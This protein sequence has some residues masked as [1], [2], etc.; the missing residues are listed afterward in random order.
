MSCIILE[1][2]L[3]S[4]H[5]CTNVH[6]LL[7]YISSLCSSLHALYCLLDALDV[8][9]PIHTLHPTSLN[10]FIECLQVPK[11]HDL[12]SELYISPA[13]ASLMEWDSRQR[14]TYRSPLEA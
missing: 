1:H 6:L 7:P 9:I 11:E 4:R 5:R 12:L 13:P 14:W 10:L 8:D 3:H 2:T